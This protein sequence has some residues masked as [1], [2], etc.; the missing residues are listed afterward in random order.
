MNHFNW[1]EAIKIN[2]N[3]VLFKPLGLVI[4]SGGITIQCPVHPSGHYIASTNFT[5]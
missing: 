1:D 4:P 3:C 2:A 5:C